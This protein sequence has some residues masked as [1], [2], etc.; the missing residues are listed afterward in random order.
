MSDSITLFQKNL[1]Y[2]F[3]NRDLLQIALTHRSYS[4]EHGLK[5]CNER[6]EFL[7]D[8]VLS[9]VVCKYLYTKYSKNDEGKLS[10]AK[11]QIVSSKNLSRWARKIKLDKFVLISKSEE[12]NLARKRENL[13]CDSFEAVIGAIFLDSSFDNVSKFINTFLKSQVNLNITDYKTTLQEIVQAKFQTLP[14]YK[15]IK[16]YGPDHDK[17]FEIAVY[18]NKNF[19]GKGKGN[20]KKEAEQNSA[21]Q[22]CKKFIN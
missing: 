2:N 12:Q 18:I 11:A 10:Q 1:G 6:M 17:T 8:S 19:F 4:C 21:K 13:L 22:A 15:I 14:E 3:K 7:G 20:S 16:E 9:A 5:Y